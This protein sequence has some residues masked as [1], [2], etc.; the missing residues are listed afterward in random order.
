MINPSKQHLYVQKPVR[1]KQY[2]SLY[3]TVFGKG[4]RNGSVGKD[5]IQEIYQTHKWM[6]KT[7]D[8]IEAMYWVDEAAIARANPSQLDFLFKGE[9]PNS[10]RY[11]A[12]L[13]FKDFVK[14]FDYMV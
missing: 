8:A 3:R 14:T 10:R 2:A 11:K 9:K 5:K 6:P 1:V 7:I 12:L 4:Y 13:I